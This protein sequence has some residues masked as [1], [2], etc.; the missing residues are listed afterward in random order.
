MAGGKHEAWTDEES[1]LLIAAVSGHTYHDASG[2]KVHWDKVVEAFE[3]AGGTARSKA[4]L[5]AHFKAVDHNP[6]A[7]MATHPG[8]HWTLGEEA[9][10]LH[11]IDVALDR[12]TGKVDWSHVSSFMFTR[13]F[14]RSA[15]SIRGHYNSLCAESH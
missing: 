15:T 2:W 12:S 3:A 4:A 14:D 5:S 9:T 8:C 13:G 1:R 11:A 6:I 7:D 10:L